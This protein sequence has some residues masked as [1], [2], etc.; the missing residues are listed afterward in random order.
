MGADVVCWVSSGLREEVSGD[1]TGAD[2]L[3]GADGYV[4]VG[5]DGH[6]GAVGPMGAVG[7]ITRARDEFHGGPQGPEAVTDGCR[8]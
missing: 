3:T 8:G 5:A 2:G 7:F 1:F 6:V 4:G